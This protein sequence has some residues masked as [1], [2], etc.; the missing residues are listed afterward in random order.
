MESRSSLHHDLVISISK[1]RKT[2]FWEG[3][4]FWKYSSINLSASLISS[5]CLTPY[6]NHSWEIHHGFFM[7]NRFDHTCICSSRNIRSLS[8]SGLNNSA[9]SSAKVMALDETPSN[10]LPS[11]SSMASAIRSSVA[12]LG[13]TAPLSILDRDTVSIPTFSAIS[14]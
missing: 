3:A 14:A 7:D 4:N 12:I 6:L 10:N 5:S 2:C 9:T 8:E 11:G 13:L 1:F